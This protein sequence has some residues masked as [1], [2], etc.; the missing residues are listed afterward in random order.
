M[1]RSDIRSAIWTTAMVVLFAVSARAAEPESEPQV[2]YRRGSEAYR[3]GRYHE[4]T[5]LLARAH[6]L[7]PHAELA[8][9][10]GRA[11]ELDGD[12]D[13]A[14]ESF[15]E[16]LRLAPQAQD[17]VVVEAKIQELERRLA[18]QPPPPKATAAEAPLP[19]A[20]SR[21]PAAPPTATDATDTREGVLRRIHLPTWI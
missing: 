1:R 9:D 21:A 5:E 6:A 10:L 15:R 8:Y 4:A 13:R 3:A 7:E 16:Y 14:V 12:L 2:L 20:T 19:P 18:R 17:Q 11:Y